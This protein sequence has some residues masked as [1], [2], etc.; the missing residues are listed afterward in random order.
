[1]FYD[2]WCVFNLILVAIYFLMHRFMSKINKSSYLLATLFININICK[3][4]FY[5]CTENGFKVQINPL[6]SENI[7][8]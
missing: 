3:T 8:K 1:M 6:M 4:V 5:Y 7:S 2:I